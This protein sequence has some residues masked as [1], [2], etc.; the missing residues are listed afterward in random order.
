MKKL[1][2]VVGF[3]SLSINSFSV[4]VFRTSFSKGAF[5]VYQL[6]R[7]D[8]GQGISTCVRVQ[9][10]FRRIACTNSLKG[11][12]LVTIGSIGRDTPSLIK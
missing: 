2:I 8:R 6:L 11:Y 1:Q 4:R 9:M 12:H 10:S 7:L 5:G 3:I